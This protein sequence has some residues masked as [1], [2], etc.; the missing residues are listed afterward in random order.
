MYIELL[1]IDA[2]KALHAYTQA[3]NDHIIWISQQGFTRQET[4]DLCGLSVE[5][6]YQILREHKER[7]EH[8]KTLENKPH[9]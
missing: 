6:V 3:R 8:D 5:R 7:E 2:K 1:R 9:Q 4:A